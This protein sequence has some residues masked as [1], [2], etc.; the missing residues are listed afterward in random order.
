[1]RH[2]SIISGIIRLQQ[3]YLP[4]DPFIDFA[5]DMFWISIHEATALIA[6]SLPLYRPLMRTSIRFMSSS[7]RKLSTG[8]SSTSQLTEKKSANYSTKDYNLAPSERSQRESVEAGNATDEEH[9]D[10]RMAMQT[11]CTKAARKRSHEV[12]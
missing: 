2:S 12:V 4:G 7:I 11:K 10:H 6:A 1:M 9:G 8:G 3:T 5:G